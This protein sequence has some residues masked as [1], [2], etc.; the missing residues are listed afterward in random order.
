MRHSL[1]WF[2]PLVVALALLAGCGSAAS[3][4]GAKVAATPVPGSADLN[5]CQVQ[6]AG[7]LLKVPDVKATQDTTTQPQ[8]IS[9]T[10]GQVLEIRLPATIRWS[11]N[12][13]DVSS[14]L[15]A[16]SAQS[17]YEASD[18]SCMWQFTAK[19]SGAIELDFS[20]G[21]VCSPGEAC[22]AV[23][24]LTSFAVTVN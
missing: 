19:A 4:A 17:L 24:R 20:G 10:K 12:P 15:N 8:P 9:L 14:I 16:E 11:L 21:L 5:G 22:P 2:S 7:G 18:S 13:T 1:R 6:A 3:G 23:A